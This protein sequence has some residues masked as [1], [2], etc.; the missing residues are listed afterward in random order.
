MNATEPA[1]ASPA[2]RMDGLSLSTKRSAVF[3]DV[4]AQ[5][6]AGGLLVLRGPEGAGK[7]ALL[8]SVAGRMH[9]DSGTATVFGLDS[10][11]QGRRVRRL[12]GLTHVHGI[13]D[14]EDNLTVAEHIAERLITF[15]PWYKPWA[16]RT[17]VKR[18][19]DKLRDVVVSAMTILRD[20]RIPGFRP[21]DVLEADFVLGIGTDT[22]VSELTPLQQF[23]LQLA[24]TSMDHTPVVA[25]DDID[26]LRDPH[27]RT[28]AWLG[29]L[30]YR[31][32]GVFRDDVQTFVV[33]CADDTQLRE[34]CER[35]PRLGQGVSVV[36][37][38]GE[39]M[40]PAHSHPDL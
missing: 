35:V 23:F 24:L 9:A 21:A 28:L 13:T 6:Q 27:E 30:L 36:D 29:V 26:L 33:T 8:L 37:I 1:E 19:V 22:Y 5:V 34:L 18:E 11:R 14:L 31:Q 12:V 38:A 16:S 17:D 39:H 7:T 20:S 4:S 15:Q 10:E 32:D 25:V 3:E 2:I 40:A